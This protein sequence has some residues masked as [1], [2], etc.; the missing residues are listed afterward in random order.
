MVYMLKTPREHTNTEPPVYEE[1]KEEV[2]MNSMEAKLFSKNLLKMSNSSQAKTLVNES[3]AERQRLKF[4][5]LTKEVLDQFDKLPEKTIHKGKLKT[6]FEIV[7]Q[8]CSDH[9]GSLD[10]EVNMGIVIDLLK[11][12]TQGNEYLCEEFILCLSGNIKKLTMKRRM[13]KRIIKGVAFF[14]SLIYPKTK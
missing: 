9:M 6:I 11:K 8:S 14:F 10:D 12:Y 7:L 13:T 2:E 5:E 1:I 3:K 4:I